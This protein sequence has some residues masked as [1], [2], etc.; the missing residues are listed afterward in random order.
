MSA[1]IIISPS[2]SIALCTRNTLPFLQ[3][4]KS[5]T[6]IFTPDSST[7]QGQKLASERC[8]KHELLNYEP[9]P[10][11]SSIVEIKFDRLTNLK[12]LHTSPRY[13]FSSQQQD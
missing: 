13:S 1:F 11:Q 12:L 4:W 8:Q 3:A 5:L 7:V 9:V 10:E 6:S 2:S